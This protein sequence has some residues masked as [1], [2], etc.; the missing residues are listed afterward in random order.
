MPIAIYE[1]MDEFTNH[2]IEINQGDCLYLM[3]DG[4]EDQFGG[5]KGKKFLSKNLKQ[6]LL[7]NS[8]LTMKKQ[9]EILEKTITDW[10]GDGEQI[11]DITVMGIKI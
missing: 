2:E 4:Y 9:K 7:D 1:R 5:L 11:D 6:L 3:S 8:Q 10:I